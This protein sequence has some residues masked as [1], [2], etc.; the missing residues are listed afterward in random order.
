MAAVSA[1]A[2]MTAEAITMVHWVRDA[3]RA[4]TRARCAAVAAPRAAWMSPASSS[5]VLAGNLSSPSAVLGVVRCGRL[6][7]EGDPSAR[8]DGTPN[9]S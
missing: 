3:S 6:A 7:C 4:E 2:A 1:N 9:A 8:A 5:T